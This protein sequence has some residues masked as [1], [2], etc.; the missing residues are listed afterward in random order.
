MDGNT[1]NTGDGEYKADL[2]D[3]YSGR[4]SNDVGRVDANGDDVITVLMLIAKLIVA[5]I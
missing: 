1:V 3:V 2:G 5:M 4:D